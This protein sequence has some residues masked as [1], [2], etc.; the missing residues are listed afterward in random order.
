MIGAWTPV[1]PRAAIPIRGVNHAPT[2]IREKQ[3]LAGIHQTARI[4]LVSG[5]VGYG[6]VGCALKQVV[7]ARWDDAYQCNIRRAIRA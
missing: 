4:N 3:G 1:W 7:T 2:G 5:D 6:G